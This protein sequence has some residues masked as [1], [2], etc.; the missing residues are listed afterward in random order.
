MATG[1]R[2]SSGNCSPSLAHLKIEEIAFDTGFNSKS[3][4]HTAFKKATQT[5]PSQYRKA[6]AAVDNGQE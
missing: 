4:F 6:A 3:A 5:T 1:L 2:K